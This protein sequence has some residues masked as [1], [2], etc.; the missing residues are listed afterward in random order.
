MSFRCPAHSFPIVLLILTGCGTARQ[1][2]TLP[3]AS[4][5][6]RHSQQHSHSH[7]AV[8]PHGGHL[9]E[10]G[11]EAYH[12][13]W[14]HDDAS[15]T[16]TVYILDSEAKQE[17]PVA[18]S[19]VSIDTKI[20]DTKVHKLAAINATGDPPQASRFQLKDPALIESLKMAGQGVEASI[21]VQIDGMQ[22]TGNFKHHEHGEEHNHSH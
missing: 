20:R 15:G 6:A 14:T 13:E 19:S 11:D 3:P 1:Q 12:V 21:R 22:Y 7:E 10:L 2:A 5:D 18:A 17:V 16:V 9:I 8:G 4:S